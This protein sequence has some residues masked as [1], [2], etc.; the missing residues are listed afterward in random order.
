MARRATLT[1]DTLVALG[2]EK[3]A[4]LVLDEAG[5]NAAFK[6]IVTAALAGA[7][8]PDAIAAIIDRRLAALERA[9]GKIEWEKRKAFAA[10]LEATLA[11]I[12]DQLG[13]ADPATAVER[14]LRFLATAAGVF[15]RVDDSSGQVQEVYSAAAGAFSSLAERL[16]DDDKAQLPERLMPL[17]LADSYGLI[18]RVVSAVIPLLPAA[19]GA[20]FDTAL[21][22]VAHE[23]G[24]VSDERRHWQQQLRRDRVIRA[25]QAIA[26][27]RGDVD[28]F[29]ALEHGC[30]AQ[31]PDSLGIAERL[32][33]AGRTSEAL[34]W[35]R[36][37]AR[38]G[39]RV[40]RWQ[41]LGDGTG[42]RDLSD[43]AQVQLEVR[44]LQAMGDHEAAQAL[45]WQTFEATLDAALL[46][47]YLAHLPDFA[48][49]EALDRAFAHAAT[50][51]HRYTS[52]AFLLAWPQLDF[53]AKLVL[54]HRETW[55]GRH[56]G[57]LVPAAEALEEAH[58]AAATVLYRALIDDIL[59]RARSPAYGH[60][61]RYLARLDALA[62]RTDPS[63]DLPD[64]AAYRANLNLAH[65]RKI[66][67]WSLVHGR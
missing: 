1:H 31:R 60:A 14:I 63:P 52:L 27:Q 53:A 64:H 9:R 34:D 47:D 22:A 17:L 20:R 3:L 55:D 29:I 62:D 65:G 16:A 67:F 46:R 25:R 54:D 2:P 58:P 33:A 42:G 61:A 4:K 40:M 23:I 21:A 8:G 49:F 15:E 28:A 56:Y 19:A 37:P 24:P 32:L 39:L 57:A 10:D 12:T 43:L 41:D 51:P 30:G 59:M 35:V 26:D 18:E 44:I 48:E 38:A 45:R 66:G 7:Q 11:T 36:R 5:R 50:Y 6:R 13:A